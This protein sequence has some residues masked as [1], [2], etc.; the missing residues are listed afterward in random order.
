MKHTKSPSLFS[1]SPAYLV[2]ALL[3]GLVLSLVFPLAIAAQD[4]DSA[5]RDSERAHHRGFM[6]H[7]MSPEER[8]AR[9][10][11]K[12]SEIDTNSDDMI[13]PDEFNAA[14]MPHPREGRHFGRRHHRGDRGGEHRDEQRDS[15]ANSDG[16]FDGSSQERAAKHAEMQVKLFE[17]MD[18]DANGTLSQAEFAEMHAAR[19]GLMKAHMFQR[20]DKN[21]DGLLGRDEFPPSHKRD[22]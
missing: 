8:Q 15:G 4:D 22:K 6:R 10:D 7:R 21:A 12:F 18:S 5:A 16:P 19:A 11:E 17:A 2:A 20:M 3:F 14:K 13:S 1:F 9:I